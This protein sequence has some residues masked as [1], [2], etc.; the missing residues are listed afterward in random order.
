MRF[1]VLALA[2]ALAVGTSA[3]AQ[4]PN[5]VLQHYRAYQAALEAGDLAAADRAGAAALE[6]SEARDGAG[7]RTA[8]LAINLATLRLGA[9]RRAEAR[10]P[11]QRARALAG[12]DS[13]VDPVM[14]E[15]ILGRAELASS[16]LEAGAARVLAA[17]ANAGP[18][19][20]EPAYD[21]AADLGGVA[22][23]RTELAIAQQAWTEA[24]RIA[25]IGTGDTWALLLARA[26]VGLGAA[27]TI[28]DRV[29]F[30]RGA[31]GGSRIQADR[32]AA[33]DV[34]LTAHSVLEAALVS[35]QPLSSRQGEGGA[36][37][38]AQQV[39]AE[40][41]V[42]L[43]ALRARMQSRGEDVPVYDLDGLRLSRNGG[44]A[45]DFTLDGPRPR[46]E[47]EELEA[48]GVASAVIG[49]AIDDAGRVEDAAVVAA[50]GGPR[51]TE[52]LRSSL[53]NWRVRRL[54]TSSPG[55]S[56]NA[57]GFIPVTFTLL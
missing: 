12:G 6:A 47:E 27:Y 15:L 28:Q 45:C 44:V 36:M 34:S 21:A 50:V 48:W 8:V 29:E 4:T 49:V 1:V 35:V 5:P 42:W 39:H 24:V 37:T 22:F 19:L 55:C 7:G 26:Q 52:S 10:G 13:G 38:V 17:T 18:D 31:P 20:A 11:A 41:L 16:D 9:D 32:G 23:A 56:M 14:A 51:F 2:V 57:V 30:A 53:S 40:A 25:R 43:A 3:A 54:A 33:E 46:L